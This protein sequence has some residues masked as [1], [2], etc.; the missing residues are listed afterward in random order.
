[1]D[2]E[3]AAKPKPF[4]C[5]DKWKSSIRQPPGSGDFKPDGKFI[6]EV[7]E[8]GNLSGK[9]KKSDNDPEIDIKSGTCKRNGDDK[10]S[11]TI[12]RE[13]D[14][15][16]Y[17]YSGAI[18]DEGGG[19]HRVEGTRKVTPKVKDERKD[20]EVFTGDDEWVAVKGT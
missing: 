15:N 19:V 12:T 8:S 13:D 6:L 9:H 20:K 7:D 2:S 10:Q 17:F 14:D 16:V 1:M 18:T 4:Q 3:S 5:G 11:M